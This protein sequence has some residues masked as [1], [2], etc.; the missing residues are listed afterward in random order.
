MPGE[1]LDAVQIAN[2]PLALAEVM[3]RAGEHLEVVLEATYGWYWATDTLAEGGASRHLAHPVG[4]EGVRVRQGEE[5]LSRLCRS[6]RP[7]ADGPHYRRR[8]SP[9]PRSRSCA[10]WSATARSWSRCVRG[11]RPRSTRSWPSAGWRCR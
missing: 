6:C 7:A 8:G 4:G 11:A 5:R 2:S 10:S 1:L 9:R 3:K